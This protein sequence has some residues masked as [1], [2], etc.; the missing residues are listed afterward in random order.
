MGSSHPLP[1]NLRQVPGHQSVP[2]PVRQKTDEGTSHLDSRSSDHQGFSSVH[3]VLARVM[4]PTR[5]EIQDG[6]QYRTSACCE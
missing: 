6:D 2:F 1:V 5:S 3:D 4:V